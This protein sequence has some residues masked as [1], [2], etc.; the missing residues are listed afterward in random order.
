MLLNRLFPFL[1]G[2]LT[3][4]LWAQQKAPD[5]IPLEKFTYY[6]V[7]ADAR[8][9]KPGAPAMPY[10]ERMQGLILSKVGFYA[11]DLQAVEG[12]TWTLRLAVA[13]DLPLSDLYE[14]LKAAGLELRLLTPVK[15]QQA[16]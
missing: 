2:L 12:P 9:Y 13:P 11:A 1:S 4:L 3:G 15:P 16:E 14:V 5:K 10:W 8:E 6:E 7:R